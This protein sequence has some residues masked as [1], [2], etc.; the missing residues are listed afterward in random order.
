MDRDLH[1]CIYIYIYRKSPQSRFAAAGQ[2]IFPASHF[3]SR[4]CPACVA[5]SIRTNNTRYSSIV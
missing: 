5:H 3:I 1:M 4:T 2:N